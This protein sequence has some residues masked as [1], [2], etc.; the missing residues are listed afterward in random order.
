M[1]T[2]SD[3]GEK[4]PETAV[5]LAAGRGTRLG[6]RGRHYP[7]GFLKFG[8]RPIIEESIDR[9]T[10]SGIRRI[11]IVTG[12]RSE[13]YLQLQSRYPRLVETVQNPI[14]GKSGSMYSLCCAQDL[15]GSDFL[16]LESDLVFEQKALTSCLRSPHENVLLLSAISESEDAVYAVVENSRLRKITKRLFE[17]AGSTIGEFVGISKISYRLYKIMLDFAEGLFSKSLH[18]EYDAH[19][20]AS[21]VKGCDIYCLLDDSLVWSDIDTETQYRRVSEKIYPLIP[22]NPQRVEV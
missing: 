4:P 11:I 3:C 2:R 22:P 19:C 15:I 16:L 20:L 8:D 9:L 14:F 5:I 13:F 6:E 7:K 21:V 17:S 1:E 12:F 18:V 10:A